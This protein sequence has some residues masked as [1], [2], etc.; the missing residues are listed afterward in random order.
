LA[1]GYQRSAFGQTV[2]FFP[3]AG[4]DERTQ[5]AFIRL[6]GDNP[7]SIRLIANR[8]ST[9]ADRLTTPTC[10]AT[11]DGVYLATLSP[12]ASAIFG[13]SVSFPQ[14]TLISGLK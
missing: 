13:D 3:R 11:A 1:V 14:V 7:R 10:C 6:I 5:S 12:V 2:G 8:S 9:F 4:F